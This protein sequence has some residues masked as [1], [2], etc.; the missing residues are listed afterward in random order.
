MLVGPGVLS[1]YADKCKEE[2][3]LGARGAEGG[4]GGSAEGDQPSKDPASQCT[5]LHTYTK[6]CIV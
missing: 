1:V 4:E 2:E 3:D 6:S 5:F